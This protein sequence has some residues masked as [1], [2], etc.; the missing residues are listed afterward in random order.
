MKISSKNVKE[1][2]IF[3]RE[4]G[5]GEDEKKKRKLILLDYTDQEKL[6]GGTTD[7]GKEVEKEAEKNLG[8]ILFFYFF[9]FLFFSHLNQFFFS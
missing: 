6:A 1:N 7:H 8:G 9:I 3:A 5:D 2:S 4:K